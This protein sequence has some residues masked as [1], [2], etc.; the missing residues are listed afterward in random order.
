MHYFLL[1][2]Q[3]RI[4]QKAALCCALALW[5]LHTFFA[6]RIRLESLEKLK[7]YCYSFLGLFFCRIPLFTCKRSRPHFPPSKTNP[8]SSF[9]CF[10]SHSQRSCTSPRIPKEASVGLCMIDE[11]LII[12]GRASVWSGLHV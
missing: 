12:R 11:F 4:K 10:C 5:F 6:L 8:F 3:N 2:E 1:V 7:F 9:Q